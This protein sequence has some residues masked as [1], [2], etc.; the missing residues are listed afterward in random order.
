MMS[1]T[2]PNLTMRRDELIDIVKT[3]SIGLTESSIVK[4]LK[5]AD[6]TDAVAAGWFHCDGAEC[7]ARQA[8]QQNQVFQGRYDTLMAQYLDLGWPYPMV[9]VEITD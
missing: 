2:Y 6:T 3:A 8:K 1:G 5:V 4:W 7:V 9:R